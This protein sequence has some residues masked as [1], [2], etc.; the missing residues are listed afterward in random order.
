MLDMAAQDLGLDRLAIR[1]RNLISLGEMPYALASV[2]PDDGFGETECDS[3]DYASTFDRCVSEARWAEKASLQGK[4]IDGRYHGLGIACFIEGGGSGPREHARMDVEADGAVTVYVGSSAIGQGLETAFAQI[5]ADA[6]ELPMARIRRVQHGSTAH[7]REGFGSFASR[8]TI[9]GGS[10]IL[11]AAATLKAQACAAA[12][13]RLGCSAAEIRWAD[14]APRAVA[15]GETVP[16]AEVARDGIAVEESY[17]FTKPTFAYGAAA[18]HVAV[19]PETGWIDV[20]DY[21]LVEDVGRIVNPLMLHGQALGALV[22]GLGGTLFE[23]LVYD[24][25]GQLLAGSLMDYAAPIAGHFPTLRVVSLALRPSP[26]NPLGVKGAGEGGIIAVGGVIA[27]AVAAA[28]RS[29]DVEPNAL[30]LSPARVWRLIDAARAAQP[31]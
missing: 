11:M 30:P 9:M 24:R 18:A 6:L 4:L 10:A 17:V 13:R 25:D 28:L 12:A 26:H 22:Q 16:L 19:D 29:L 31:S 14:G 20:L 8:A 5:A 23:H 27:N 15:S 21:L 1:R 7:V 2:L 3:G